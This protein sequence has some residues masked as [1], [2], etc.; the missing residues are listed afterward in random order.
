MILNNIGAIAQNEWLKTPSIRP[1][2]NLSLDEFVVMP[3]HFHAIIYIGE[4]EFNTNTRRDG[5]HSVSTITTEDIAINKF[6]PQSKN[7]GS[8]IRGFKASVSVQVR[9]L[10]PHFG[11]QERYHDHIIRDQESF[12]RIQQYILSN[13]ANWKR[14]KFYSELMW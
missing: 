1:D 14:D 5:M 12:L 6:G 3:N 7:L 11:W 9:K 4:N 10:I 2:M 13:P 8:I